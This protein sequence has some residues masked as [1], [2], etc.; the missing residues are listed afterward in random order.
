MTDNQVTDNK[1]EH[2]VTETTNETSAGA[3]NETAS[4]P[5]TDEPSAPK[6]EQ[7]VKAVDPE[8]ANASRLV[9]ACVTCISFL[10]SMFLHSL[11]YLCVVYVG[12]DMFVSV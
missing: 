11:I 5:A 6:H 3:N 10:A 9:R 1:A 12:M 2:A 8:Q 4:A 7:W